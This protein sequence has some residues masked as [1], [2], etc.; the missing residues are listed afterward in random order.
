MKRVKK[1]LRALS[2]RRMKNQFFVFTSVY[3]N[4]DDSYESTCVG[5]NELSTLLDE[6]Q[7]KEGR[8]VS[9]KSLR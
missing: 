7:E 2:F 6:L 1:K 3:G 5:N 9:R 4:R 8:L